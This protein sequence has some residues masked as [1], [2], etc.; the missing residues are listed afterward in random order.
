[1]NFSSARS[2]ARLF[3][4]LFLCLF[5]LLRAEFN[6]VYLN[7]RGTGTGTGTRKTKAKQTDG[8][9]RIAFI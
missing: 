1:M 3:E 5:A 6:C 9:E 4:I 7:K 2:L 8:R